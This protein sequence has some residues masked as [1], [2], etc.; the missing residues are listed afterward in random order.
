MLQRLL[1]FLEDDPT[2]YLDEMQQ[3]L[4]DE[5]ELE[6][7]IATISRTL[8]RAKWSRK[9]YRHVLLRGVSHYGMHG[10]VSRSSM[11]AINLSFLMSQLQMSTLVIGSMVGL[12]QAQFVSIHVHSRGQR[13]GVSCQHLHMRAILIGLYSKVLSLQS[14]FQSLYKSKFFPIALHIQGLAQCLFWTMLL[15]IRVLSFAICV[16]REGYY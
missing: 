9:L 13:D 8:K 4:Y 10:K 12:L 16:R 7:S 14:C 11:I 15:S 6:T 2:A 5:Y 3:F 1:D